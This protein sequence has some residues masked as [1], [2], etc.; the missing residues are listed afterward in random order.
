MNLKNMRTKKYKL[1][2]NKSA[3]NQGVSFSEQNQ[4]ND[5]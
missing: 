1:R 4:K 3:P 2:I 5:I